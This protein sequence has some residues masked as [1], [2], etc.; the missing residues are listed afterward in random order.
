M[1]L[2]IYL[3][4]HAFAEDASGPAE[5]VERWR[6]S[7]FCAECG[8]GI[9]TA[10]DAALIVTTKRVVHKNKCFIPALLRANPHLK[11]LADRK[12]QEA[13]PDPSPL[14]LLRD[15]AREIQ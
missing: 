4:I 1:A 8:E 7:P 6:A 15:E 9:Q 10:E 12:Q 3:G 13:M 2:P 5:L 11:L 14:R